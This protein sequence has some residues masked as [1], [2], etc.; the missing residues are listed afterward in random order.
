MVRAGRSGND[1]TM[2]LKGLSCECGESPVVL[3][4]GSFPSS[5]SLA[6]QEYY[7]NPRNQFWQIFEILYGIPREVTYRKRVESLKSLGI[8]LWD[9]IG[10]CEREGSMDQRIHNATVNNIPGFLKRYPGI[11]LIVANGSTAGRYFKKAC[12][13]DVSGIVFQV[14]PSTSPANTTRSVEEKARIWSVIRQ[15]LPIERAP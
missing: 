13:G 3:I 4:L 6:N 9:C 15:Y 14:L 11:R 5:Q 2:M 10:S 7:A 12:P 8:T 1:G